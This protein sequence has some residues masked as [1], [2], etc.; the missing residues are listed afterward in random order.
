LGEGW[1][2][3]GE[4]SDGTGIRIREGSEMFVGKNIVSLSLSER[5]ET[6]KQI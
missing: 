2:G 1:H 6:L 3:I 5:I 4:V